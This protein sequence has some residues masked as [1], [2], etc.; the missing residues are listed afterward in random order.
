MVIGKKIHRIKSC[1]STNDLA[2]E[3]VLKGAEEGTV[4]LSKEQT[5]GRGTKDRRWFSPAGKGLYLSIILCPVSSD[6]TLIPIMVGIAVGEAIFNYSGIRVLLK[7]PNDLVFRD[8]KLGGILCESSFL[9]NTVNYVILGIG[10]NISHRREDFPVELV[11]S[12]TS[13]NLVS[14]KPFEQKLFLE[15]L[16]ESL[17]NWYDVFNRGEKKML[18]ETFQEHS[19]F[20]PGEG[21]KIETETSKVSGLYR[22]I[23]DSGSL[24]MKVKGKE[25]AFFSASVRAIRRIKEI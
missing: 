8:L 9:G 7:W 2:R 19:F 16:W 12:A 18:V 13:F 1:S 5:K 4:V 23:D 22:G 24:L 6:I 14:D 17:D 25:K 21:V 3:L 15:G 11:N 10:L 20:R